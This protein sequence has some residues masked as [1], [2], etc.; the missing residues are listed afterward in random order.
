MK[1][2]NF[3]EKIE[4]FFKINSITRSDI[5]VQTKTILENVLPQGKFSLR[6][7]GPQF[8]K[9]RHENRYKKRHGFLQKDLQLG[10]FKF[11]Q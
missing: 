10:N 9:N 7:F 6:F 4:K 5:A 1:K 3:F 11:L 2:F 8:I